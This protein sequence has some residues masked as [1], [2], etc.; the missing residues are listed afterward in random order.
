[1]APAPALAPSPASALVVAPAD[2]LERSETPERTRVWTWVA[3]GAALALLG[4]G[5]GM[6]VATDRAYEDYEMAMTD[7]EWMDHRDRVE[8][9]Q[10]WTRVL[11]GG[12]GAAAATA[13]ICWAMRW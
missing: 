4:G 2:P 12:A 11:L 6:W 5:V 13:G 3:A 1:V 7:A 8:T 10:T 9:R